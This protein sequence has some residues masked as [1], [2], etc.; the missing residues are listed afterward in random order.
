LAIER[1]LDGAILVMPTVK[2]VAPPMAPLATD[3]ALF[4][5][6]NLETL[7][8]TMIGSLLDMP[9]VAIPSGKD[10]TGLA[11]STLFSTTRG[12]DDHLLGACLS[13]E[14]TLRAAVFKR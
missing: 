7:S 12:R 14:A 10:S 11:T 5:S 6:V 4:A 2:H 3:D 9:G 1:E 13:I 8:L